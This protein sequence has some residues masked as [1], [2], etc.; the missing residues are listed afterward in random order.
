MTMENSPWSE[1]EIWPFLKVAISLKPEWPCPPK[2]V[3]M[4]LTSIPTCKNSL[5]QFRLI[6][7]FDDHGYSPWS[8]RE[9]W[10]FLKVA[11]S[12]KPEKIHLP[13]LVCMHATSIPTS[14]NFLSQFRLIEFF[15]DHG[16]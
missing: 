4:H 5:S 15:D 2:L 9:I 1:R 12:P 13:K 14:I 3:C 11:I 7:F 8:E 10:P 16:L 6:E